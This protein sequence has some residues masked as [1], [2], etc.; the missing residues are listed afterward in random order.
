M[1]ISGCFS[2]RASLLRVTK[3]RHEHYLDPGIDMA[4]ITRRA[5]ESAGWVVDRSAGNVMVEL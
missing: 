2:S 1:L 3:C 5:A 4:G